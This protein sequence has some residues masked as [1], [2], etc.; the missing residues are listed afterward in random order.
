MGRLCVYSEWII[1]KFTKI[2]LFFALIVAFIADKRIFILIF[3]V[4]G[5][6]DAG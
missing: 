3:E 5:N 6:H 2:A 1:A 4:R